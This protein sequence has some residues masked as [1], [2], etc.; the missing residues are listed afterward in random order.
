M[1][2]TE[3]WACLALCGRLLSRWGTGGLLL[4]GATVCYCYTQTENIKH[5]A[6]CVMNA[7]ILRMIPAW[8]VATCH[9]PRDLAHAY[10]SHSK[11]TS[12]PGLWTIGWS[13]PLGVPVSVHA[14]P[15]ALL[16][17]IQQG[18][19]DTRN[20]NYSRLYCLLGR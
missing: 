9:S 7:C 11:Q 3:W 15:L 19:S 10:L 17:F 16:W 13:V 8:V 20:L 5:I 14:I 4:A 6:Q 18:L 12:S 1:M 2:S